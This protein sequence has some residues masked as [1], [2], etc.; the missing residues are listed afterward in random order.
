VLGAYIILNFLNKSCFILRGLWSVT[1][2]KRSSSLSSQLQLFCL[3]AY[4]SSTAFRAC[5]HRSLSRC[6]RIPQFGCSLKSLCL[7][8]LRPQSRLSATPNPSKVVREASPVTPFLF[9]NW[10]VTAACVYARPLNR[11]GY[12]LVTVFEKSLLVCIVPSVP[13][14]T[15]H[16]QSLLR[17]PIHSSQEWAYFLLRSYSKKHPHL[18]KISLR[19]SKTCAKPLCILHR[20]PSSPSGFLF[21]L[22]P[23]LILA[24]ASRATFTL[25]SFLSSVSFRLLPTLQSAI[26]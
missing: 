15:K 8:S 5:M 14:V 21:G 10:G 26:P 11:S 2:E 17:I 7:F 22:P 20:S 24:W 25:R 12:G 19:N 3:Q 13:P 1:W 9:I 16:F 4:T 18:E 6:S 23:S